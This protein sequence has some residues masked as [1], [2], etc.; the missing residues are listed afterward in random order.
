MLEIAGR[1]HAE[2]EINSL[3]ARLA[4]AETALRDCI[5]GH[6]VKDYFVKNSNPTDKK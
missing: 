5:N 4:E 2:H 1:S 3:K 6:D